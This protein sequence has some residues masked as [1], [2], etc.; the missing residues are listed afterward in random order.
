MKMKQNFKTVACEAVIVGNVHRLKIY[1]NY[2]TMLIQAQGFRLQGNYNVCLATCHCFQFSTKT[3]IILI[4]RE[5]NGNKKTDLQRYFV[6]FP[7]SN[8]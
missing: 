7:V 1:K 4:F 6:T 8:S 3:F 2:I 5:N